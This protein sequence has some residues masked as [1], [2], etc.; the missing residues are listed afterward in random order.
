MLENPDLSLRAPV[1]ILFIQT[2]AAPA[3]WLFR[4]KAWPWRRLH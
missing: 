1:L 3:G 2:Y 4:D